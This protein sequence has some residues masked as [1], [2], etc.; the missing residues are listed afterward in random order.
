[1]NRGIVLSPDFKFLP[2]GRTFFKASSDP[3][4]L[5]KYLLYW[6]KIDVPLTRLVRFSSSDFDFLSDSGVLTRTPYA[7]HNHSFAEIRDS[8]RITLPRA[9]GIEILEAH[10][11]VFALMTSREPGLW[12][13]AQMSTDLMAVNGVSREVIEIELYNLVPVPNDLTPLG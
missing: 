12:S 1:M 6:D 8:Y 9:A 4:E 11:A 3:D 13:K 2:N 10:N 7:V 5:R